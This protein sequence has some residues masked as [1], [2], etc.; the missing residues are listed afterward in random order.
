MT[1]LHPCCQ[2]LKELPNFKHPTPKYGSFLAG[3]PGFGDYRTVPHPSGGGSL[4]GKV[5]FFGKGA[6]NL[7]IPSGV[8]SRDRELSIAEGITEF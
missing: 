5:E 1:D 4:A 8:D 2:K 7:V 3:D 6:Q